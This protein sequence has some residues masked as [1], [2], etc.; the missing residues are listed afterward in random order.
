MRKGEGYIS[1]LWFPLL[2]EEALNV[3]NNCATVGN[4]PDAV[5]PLFL[6]VRCWSLTSLKRISKKGMT[7]TI[8]GMAQDPAWKN[9]TLI[10]FPGWICDS[11]GY[12]SAGSCWGCF[13]CPTV[14][15]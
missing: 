4:E 13:S 14:V 6:F 2:V 15:L 5:I 12:A 9:S 11:N 7:T 3:C 8:F 10:L 1:T